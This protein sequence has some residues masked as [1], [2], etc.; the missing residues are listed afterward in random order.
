M[1]ETDWASEAARSTS[2][3]GKHLSKHLL[4]LCFQ[5]AGAAGVANFGVA[6]KYL[7]IASENGDF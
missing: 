1:D 6:A 5:F 4:N 2:S 3:M 7:H